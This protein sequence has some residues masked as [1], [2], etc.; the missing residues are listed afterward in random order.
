MQ[1]ISAAIG[2]A[3]LLFGL[4]CPASF[5]LGIEIMVLATL[6]GQV[7]RSPISFSVRVTM[8]QWMATPV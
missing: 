2:T 8:P 5:V 3:L 1:K 4:T 7:Q 6:I